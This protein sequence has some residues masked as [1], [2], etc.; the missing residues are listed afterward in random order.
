MGRA[1]SRFFFR[2]AGVSRLGFWSVRVLVIGE[3]RVRDREVSQRGIVGSGGEFPMQAAR[4]DVRGILV[5]NAVLHERIVRNGYKIFMGFAAGS[6][7]REGVFTHH[8][9]RFKSNVLQDNGIS[10]KEALFRIESS[11]KCE[12][13][14]LWSRSRGC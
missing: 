8:S 1:T 10:H 3:F 12:L 5:A 14:S 11:R 2:T 4:A 9:F 6:A 7:N 13:R